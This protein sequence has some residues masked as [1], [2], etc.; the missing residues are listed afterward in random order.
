V[1]WRVALVALSVFVLMMARS[2]QSLRDERRVD[3]LAQQALVAGMYVPTFPGLTADG[4]QI[5]IGGPEPQ[6]LLLLRPDGEYSRRSLATWQ[7]LADK[8]DPGRPDAV[9]AIR[10]DEFPGMSPNGSGFAMRLPLVSFP[11]RRMK[12]MFRGTLVP[13]TLIVDAEGLVRYARPGVFESA[14]AV[15]SVISVWQTLNGSQ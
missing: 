10:T 12:A 13:Q 7:S 9:V 3:R 14:A 1:I 11:S 2:A 5:E 4:R 6:V 15:D 8:L